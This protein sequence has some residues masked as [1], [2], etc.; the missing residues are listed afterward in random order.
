[1]RKLYRAFKGFFHFITDFWQNRYI[2][3]QLVK[4]DFQSRYLGSY[5]GLPWAFLRPLMNI[6]VIWFAFTYGLRTGRIQDG[7]P[8]ILWFV[9]AEIPWTFISESIGSAT[10]CIGEYRFLIKNITFRPSIIPFIKIVT[11]FFIHFFFIG[12]IMVMA[13]AYG[14]K[15][16]IYWLQIFYYIFATVMLL[17]G[18]AWLT[19]SIR[20]FVKDVGQI[21]GVV[22]Q[23]M[24]WVT[25]IIWPYTKLEGN[26]TLIA[27]LNPFFYITEGYRETFIYKVWFFE[28]Y[29]L[30]ALFW[31]ITF[32]VFAFG[33][34]VFKKLKPHFADVL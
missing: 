8:F 25:P 18:I 23:T 29:N 13:I 26:Y 27:K 5:L 3:W 21:V 2:F 16:S 20:V 32:F 12:F 17:A 24:F 11:A 31:A 9:A 33:A 1:M 6:L 4:R 14:Y 28:H 30:T 22:L 7:T 10:G 19:S 15:P 34:F